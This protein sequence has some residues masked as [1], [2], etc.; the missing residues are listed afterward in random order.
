[1]K[2]H[3]QSSDIHLLLSNAHKIA[4][5]GH[6]N[7]DGDA[8]GSCLGLGHILENQGKEISYYTPDE[9]SHS[10]DFLEWIKK[11]KTTFDYH[12]HYDLL[13][14]LDSAD[15]YVMYQSF[16]EG[17]EEYFAKMETLV[18][19]HHVSNTLYA[20][21]NLVDDSSIATCEIVAELIYELYPEQMNELIATTLFLWLSTDSGHFVYERDSL[22]TFETASY[23]LQS[24]ADKRS[25]I[26]ALYRS[27]SLSW[28]QFIWLLINRIQ[29]QWTVIRTWY[30]KDE[31]KEYDVDKEKAD[32]ILG[33]MTRIKH[34]GIFA[35]VKIHDNEETPSYL[36]AS[37]RSKWDIDV[38]KIAAQFGGYWKS[39]LKQFIEKLEQQ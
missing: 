31:L 29:K 39:E 37:L 3:N 9:P 18:I 27:T 16:W 11:I 32:S 8:L 25:I 2:K 38:S 10:F 20:K 1:M 15:P 6:R 34:N 7:I 26:D 30:R 23:L 17:H 12:P 24:W 35:L 21:T 4:I 5:F 13:I 28:T 36:K 14:F 22:R 19:D 33:I